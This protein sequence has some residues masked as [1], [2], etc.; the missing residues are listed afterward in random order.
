[1]NKQL[2]VIGA[3]ALIMIG[4]V[5]I[6][7]AQAI[8]EGN[9]KMTMVTKMD[10][11]DDEMADAMKEME[12]LSPAEKAM[13]QQMMGGMNINTDSGAPGI[14]TS[15]SK[16]VTNND[17]IPEVT[18]EEDCVSTHTTAGNTV[19][20]DIQ[21]PD[22]NSSGEVMYMNESMHGSITTVQIADGQQATIDISGEYTGP[23]EQ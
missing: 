12:S 15:I 16:C 9:W 22:S 23:C 3:A 2:W 4:S 13:M 21:C 8:K 10:G 17:P 1:M 20:F 6:A 7:A 5:R 14:T 18:T 19:H 11:A